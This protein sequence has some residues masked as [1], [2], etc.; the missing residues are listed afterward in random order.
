[1]VL[2]L[3]TAFAECFGG[4]DGS[5]G[6]GKMRDKGRGDCVGCVT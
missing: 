3:V 5:L 2:V 1:M 6:K 4:C